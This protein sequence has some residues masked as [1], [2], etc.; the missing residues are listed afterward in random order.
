MDFLRFCCVVGE[1]GGFLE[2]ADLLEELDVIVGVASKKLSVCL[3][4]CLCYVGNVPWRLC[5]AISMFRGL[6]DRRFV[7]MAGRNVTSIVLFLIRVS[8][9]LLY[10]EYCSFL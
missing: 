4:V 6:R 3:C 8:Y 9:P 5:L 2:T 7:L 10:K 1:A